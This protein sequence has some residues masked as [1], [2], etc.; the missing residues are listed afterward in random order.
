MSASDDLSRLLAPLPGFPEKWQAGD[1][2]F[3]AK[4]CADIDDLL[5]GLKVPMSTG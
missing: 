5:L 2:A 1:C 3:L 4:F